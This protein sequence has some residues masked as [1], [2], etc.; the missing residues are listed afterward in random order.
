MTALQDMASALGKKRIS[1][2]Q[3]FL[4]TMVKGDPK[5][6]KLLAALEASHAN[7]R[8]ICPIHLEESI[9]ESAF[10]PEATR[11]KIFAL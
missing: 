2:D 7:G 9:F 8:I 3:C 11:Q 10:L 5:S 6:Q 4:S 1:I